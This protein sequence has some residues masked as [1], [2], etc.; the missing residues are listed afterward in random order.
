MYYNLH[1]LESF[2][3]SGPLQATYRR[4][5]PLTHSHISLAQQ[6]A[7]VRL[8]TCRRQSDKTIW[9]EYTRK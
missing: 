7:W 6:Q 3:V 4:T 8:R 9:N 2:S 1:I 5:R